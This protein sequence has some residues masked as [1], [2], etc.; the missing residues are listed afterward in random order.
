M[1][2]GKFQCVAEPVWEVFLDSSSG[3]PMLP[4]AQQAWQTG[5]QAGWGDPM[6]LHRS[7]RLAAQALDRAR[8]VVA[9]AV[10]ARP[11][12]VVFTA[13]GAHSSYAAVAGLAQGRRRTGSRIVTT[14]VDHSSV[15]GAAAAS[16]EHHAVGVDHQGRVDLDR[17]VDALA[18]DGT[19]LATIQ[20]ANHEVGTLQ[21]YAAGDRGRPAGG[22]SGRAGRDGGTGS[23][24]PQPQHRLV[25]A[26]R[27]GRARSAGR[28][29]SACW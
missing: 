11:D 4:D 20:V 28:P 3:E 2:R 16:G 29:R 9:G 12:E 1:A 23:D 19:A 6:R 10:G 14:A 5:Q 25:G 8:E 17:W 13:S 7:G 21:P 26:D 27:V 24:R 15:L 22:R 18:V